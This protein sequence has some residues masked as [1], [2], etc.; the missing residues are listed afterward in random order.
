MASLPRLLADLPSKLED[1]PPCQ[2]ALERPMKIVLSTEL[3]EREIYLIGSIVAQWGFLEADIFD[4][5]LLSFT[6]TDCLPTAMNNAQFSGVMELWRK[7]VIPQHDQVRQKVL[8]AQYE[9]I[10]SLNEH[11]Q[12]IVHSRWEWHPQAPEEITAVR[13]HKKNV[14][15]QTFTA[16]DLEELSV[17]IG[18]LRYSIRYPGGLEDR[19]A[20]MSKTGGY[21]SRMGWDLLS[22]RTSIE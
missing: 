22:G 19:A 1:G 9:E 12:A 15:R 14:K 17:R 6:D 21:I 2:T 7:R 11:R 8:I 16:D 18:A 4:Q 3:S 13:V 5:T 20:E 10:V